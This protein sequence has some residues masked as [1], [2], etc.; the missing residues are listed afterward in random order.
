M[1]YRSS[2][3]R[4][5]TFP[6]GL[7]HRPDLAAGVPGIELIEPVFDARKIVVHTVGVNGVK[8]VVDGDEADFMLGEGDVDIHSGHSR[9]P[10]KAGQV[11][12]DNGR[13]LATL[14]RLQHFLKPR[15]L[16]AGARVAVIHE[17]DGGWGN[18]FPWRSA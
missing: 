16:K 3:I 12:D 9:I 4:P 1:V 11:F 6:F 10:A 14:H 8:V 18:G 15:P 2:E 5:A 13:Y 17:K 7:I